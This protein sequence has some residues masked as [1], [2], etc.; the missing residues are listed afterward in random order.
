MKRII[1]TAILIFTFCI[2]IFAQGNKSACPVISVTSPPDLTLPLIFKANVSKEVGNFKVEYFWTAEGG[3]IM[4]GQNTE[5]VEIMPT[6]CNNI[7]AS[8]T[9]KDLPKE[10]PNILS[11]WA[12][13]SDGCFVEDKTS[14]IPKNL[15]AKVDEIVMFDEFRNLSVKDEKIRFDNLFMKINDDNSLKA[16]IILKFDSNNSRKKKIKKLQS[17]AKYLDDRKVDIS[18]FNFVIFD[19]KREETIFYVEPLNADSRELLS[20]DEKKHKI[21]NAVNLNQ[22]IKSLFTKK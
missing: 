12:A 8:F 13:I 5:T 9:I 20:M 14:F 18:R 11:E 4:E 15:I 6:Q 19:D 1:F 16:L 10:C 17:I 21:I 2:A 7:K 3:N 22:E